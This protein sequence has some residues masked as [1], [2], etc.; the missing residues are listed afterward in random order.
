MSNTGI[1]G[2]QET[3]TAKEKVASQRRAARVLQVY[4]DNKCSR[5]KTLYPLF[6]NQI[7]IPSRYVR[8]SHVE[9]IGFLLLLW[10][11]TNHVTCSIIVKDAVGPTRN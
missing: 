11:N 5:V 8:R 10:S 1:I 2:R 6:V 7:A 3:I 4:A 9:H